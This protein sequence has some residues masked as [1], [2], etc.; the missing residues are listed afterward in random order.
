[1]ILL[2]QHYTNSFILA[3]RDSSM[4]WPFRSVNN[5]SLRWN[6]EGAPR[7]AV[8]VQLF[9]TCWE[10]LLL[11]FRLVYLCL[12]QVCVGFVAGALVCIGLF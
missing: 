4:P 12:G 5:S 11:V 6:V 9:A 8:Y 3:A 1:M 7:H 10:K 2:K